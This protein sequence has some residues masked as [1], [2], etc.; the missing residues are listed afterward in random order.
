MVS[1]RLSRNWAFRVTAILMPLVVNGM[2]PAASADNG[3][4]LSDLPKQFPTAYA[5]WTQSV[6]HAIDLADWLTKLNGI[7]S[8]IRDVSGHGTRLKFG[9]VC[10]PHASAETG[11]RHHQVGNG[12]PAAD[13]ADADRSQ[14]PPGESGP[15]VLHLFMPVACTRDAIHDQDAMGQGQHET[16]DAA[17]DRPADAIGIDRQQHAGRG[18]RRHIAVVVTDAEPRHD[19]DLLPFVLRRKVDSCGIVVEWL[20]GMGKRSFGHCRTGWDVNSS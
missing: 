1:G 10:V 3:P 16:E 8:P 18:H 11:V 4:Y 20:A 17:R 12:L 9:T 19:N 5:N 13:V 2:Q 14:C 15:D 6:P 7:A